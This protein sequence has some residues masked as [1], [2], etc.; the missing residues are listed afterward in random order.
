MNCETTRKAAPASCAARFILPASSSKMRS[1]A[2]FSTALRPRR[3]RRLLH[4]DQRQDAP[5]NRADHLVADL[6]ASADD[7][8]PSAGD[9]YKTSRIDSVS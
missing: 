7:L 2:S 4:A 5:A 1:S 3:R 9:R 6:D 8:D